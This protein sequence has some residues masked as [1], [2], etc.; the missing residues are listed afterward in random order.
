MYGYKHYKKS[1]TYY[2]HII[3]C[4]TIPEVPLNQIIVILVNLENLCLLL[5][6][7][8]LGYMI[9]LV[10][11]QAIKQYAILYKYIIYQL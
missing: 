1:I 10:Y 11:N 2:Y 7:F 8:C 3:L 4:I 6:K 5:M 9:H